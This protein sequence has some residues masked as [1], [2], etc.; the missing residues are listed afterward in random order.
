[1]T[2]G[3]VRL[4]AV[5][6]GALC[7]AT[8]AVSVIAM[9]I[10]LYTGMQLGWGRLHGAAA[11][12]ANAILLAQFPIGHTVLLT[13]RGR[14]WLS[15]LA[16]RPVGGRLTTTTYVLIASIQVALV[17]TLWSPSGTILWSAHGPV[18]WALST[19][20]VGAWL[21]LGKSIYDAGLGVQ[22]GY[23]G[24][25]SVYRGHKTVYGPMPARGLFALCRQPIYVS[26]TLILWTVPTWTLDSVAIALAW[27]LY[28]LV[29]PLHKEALFATRYGDTFAR[30]QQRV[31]YWLPAIPFGD[32]TDLASS[33]REDVALYEE[34]GAGWWT[35]DRYFLRGL[36][37]LVKPRM[38]W[39]R[40]IAGPWSGCRVLDL[41]CAGGFMSE[42]MAH[43]GARV[44]GVDPAA[45]AIE[46]AR[47][48]AAAGQL[49]I[50]Y[51][52]GRAEAI[53]LPDAS[54]DRVVC[55]DVLEHVDD[56]Q[57]S[58]EE[59]ARVLKPGGL[60]L[61][62]TVN[63]TRLSRWIMIGLAERVLRLLPDGTHDPRKFIRPEELRRCLESAGLAC[64]SMTGL[65]PLGFNWRGDP[66]FSRWP[67]LSVSYMGLAMRVAP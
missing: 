14:R 49:E 65:G 19:A 29:G 55:V 11:W 42:A 5:T 8:F 28:C 33:R 58:C 6:S 22:T 17:F 48:H 60:L 9:G 26:F 64:G 38:R 52:I 23:L 10:S 67:V 51:V 41:G 21:L 16:P 2:A 62:D 1:M 18:R 43:E 12:V 57:A 47:A 7:H 45:P 36:R 61:F 20:F 32:P 34:H 44:I 24:W 35:S 3:A 56:L 50:Q 63:R 66:V 13:P 27:T 25:T 30:Y 46:A 40:R 15:R 59:I 31:P 39:F 37:A 4:L 53:P 54:V